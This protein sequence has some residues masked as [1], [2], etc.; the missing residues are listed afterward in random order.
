[1]LATPFELFDPARKMP[2]TRIDKKTEYIYRKN[3]EK[4]WTD[5]NNLSEEDIKI[6]ELNRYESESD[7]NR[8]MGT[9]ELIKKN[10]K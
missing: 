9:F 5:I 2:E 4:E 8:R 6:F 3:L 1:M 10:K 7:K